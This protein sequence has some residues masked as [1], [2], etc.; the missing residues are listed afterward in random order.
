MH[1]DSFTHGQS[2]TCYNMMELGANFAM[3]EVV[4]TANSCANVTMI[5]IRTHSVLKTHSFYTKYRFPWLYIVFSLL[6]SSLSS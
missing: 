2:I 4:S 6:D 5:F 1:T 3:R